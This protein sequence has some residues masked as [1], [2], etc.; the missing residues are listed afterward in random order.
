MK[1]LFH[2]RLHQ[3]AFNASITLFITFEFAANATFAVLLLVSTP[4]EI[5]TLSGFSLVFAAPVTNRVLE[6][7]VLFSAG[8]K[9]DSY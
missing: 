4:K 1:C 2:S 9:V 5:I 3:L 6:L 7:L 8:R